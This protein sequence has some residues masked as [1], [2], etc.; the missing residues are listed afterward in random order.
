MLADDA[1]IEAWP[2]GFCESTITATISVLPFFL[3]VALLARFTLPLVTGLI[4]LK[5]FF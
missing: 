4:L 1:H 2:F 5:A 3:A